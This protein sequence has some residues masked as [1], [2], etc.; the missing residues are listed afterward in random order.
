ML[1]NTAINAVNTAVNTVVTCLDVYFYYKVALGDMDDVKSRGCLELKTGNTPLYH[2]IFFY[3]KVHLGGV[4]DVE[5]RGC[6][7][8]NMENTGDPITGAL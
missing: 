5:F 6:R 3:Y 8:L 2:D 4:D 7:K 1:C